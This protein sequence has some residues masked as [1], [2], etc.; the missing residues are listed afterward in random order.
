MATKRRCFEQAQLAIVFP[1]PALILAGAVKEKRPATW[2]GA[3]LSGAMLYVQ[4]LA[5]GN[6][7]V[8]KNNSEASRFF[9][10]PEGADTPPRG[11]KKKAAGEP[12]AFEGDR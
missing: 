5:G 1:P 6:A 2:P 9:T 12:A 11:A 8:A 3:K 4:F 7:N 10:L